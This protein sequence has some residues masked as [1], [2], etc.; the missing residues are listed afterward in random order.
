MGNFNSY[1]FDGNNQSGAGY[2]DNFRDLQNNIQKLVK[3]SHNSA[4][5]DTIAFNN[6]P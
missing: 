6:S 4:T 1:Q 2:S 5:T 3:K